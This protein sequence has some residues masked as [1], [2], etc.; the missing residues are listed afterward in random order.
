LAWPPDVPVYSSRG[1]EWERPGDAL[2]DL[3][4]N[5]SAL[6]DVTTGIPGRTIFHDR[7]KQALL[8]ARRKG[9]AVSVMFVSVDY[10]KLIND[11]LGKD[12]GDQLLCIVAGRL[13]GCLRNSDTVARPG[14]DEFMILLPEIANADDAARVAAKIFTSLNSTFVLGGHELFV[15][16]NIGISV[17]PDDGDDDISLI[18]NSY[19]AMQHA[20]E[21]GKNTY[22]FYSPAINTK[23]FNRMV[24]ENC[25]RLALGREEFFLNYQ[26][27]MDLRSGHVSGLEA[28][29]RW[30]RPGFGV[31]YPNSFIPLMEESGL[32]LSLGEWVLYNACTQNKLWQESGLRPVRVAVNISARHFQQGDIVDLVGR[33]L[34]E[35]G[36][37]PQFLDLELT[38]SIF[39]QNTEA[40]VEALRALRD[41]GVQISIDDF[42]TGYSSL[43]Y[44]KYFPINKLKMVEPFV[45]VI[46]VHPND[47]VIARAIVAMAHSL[48][49]KVIAEGVENEQHLAFLRSLECDELQGNIFSHPVPVGEAV[50]FLSGQ[51]MI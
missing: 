8:F 14:R 12:V 4:E 7:L 35:T 43:S 38:E 42:G 16:A 24:M 2:E 44:L 1:G 47:E 9:N 3:K 29:V 26:P 46:A 15:D 48:N 45:S 11:T 22:K 10:L 27:Q 17:Y 34:G 33:V 50:R 5:D 25:L 41:M 32:I 37:G 51:R 31:V 40:A 13:K 49:M 6:Y 21:A 39:M 30:D 23:A 19:A 36:L 28:L 18:R 20:V